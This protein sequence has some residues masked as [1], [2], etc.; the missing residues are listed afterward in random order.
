MYQ[1]DVDVVH[2]A[3]IRYNLADSYNRHTAAAMVSMMENC[4]RP[5]VFHIVHEDRISFKDKK[6]A[7]Q[8]IIKYSLKTCKLHKHFEEKKSVKVSIVM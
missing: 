3:I 5:I 7:E 6:S 8:N 2:V 4:S 1:C